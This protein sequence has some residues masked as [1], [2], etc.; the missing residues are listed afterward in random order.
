M[1]RSCALSLFDAANSLSRFAMRIMALLV[2][3]P[4]QL[5]AR[6]LSLLPFAGVLAREGAVLT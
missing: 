5:G 4:A 2:A 3:L 6:L 1:A